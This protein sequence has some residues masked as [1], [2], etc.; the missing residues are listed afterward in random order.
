LSFSRLV[1]ATGISWMETK[2]Q[3]AG[4]EGGTAIEDEQRLDDPETRGHVCV[5]N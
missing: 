4:W 1:L 3:F 2:N 5:T